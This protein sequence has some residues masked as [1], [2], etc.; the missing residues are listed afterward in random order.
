MLKQDLF[1]DVDKAERYM[2]KTPEPWM[3]RV[4]ERTRHYMEGQRNTDAASSSLPTVDEITVYICL[5]MEEET[6]GKAHSKKKHI[7]DP[8][9]TPVKN[10]IF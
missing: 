2:G 10:K 4:A 6:Q 8:R 9:H 7:P 1:S 3:I 5:S